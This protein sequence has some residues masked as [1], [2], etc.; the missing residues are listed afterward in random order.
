MLKIRRA[1]DRGVAIFALSGRI[2]EE[3]LSELQK[4]IEGETATK[5][6]F[7]LEE[8]KIV[9]RQVVKF[10]MACEEEGIDLRNCPGYV[11]EWMG[12]RRKSHGSQL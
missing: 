2:E 9:G 7:D 11:Q 3:D 5:K 6:A 12:T 4:L 1:E 10:L 8:V